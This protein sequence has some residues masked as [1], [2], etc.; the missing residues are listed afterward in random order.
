MSLKIKIKKHNNIPVV[1]IIGEAVGQDVVKISKKLEPYLTTSDP[2]IAIDL[3]GTTVV[4]SYGLGVFIFSWKQFTGQNRQLI[5]VNPQGFV[6]DLFEGTNL[7]KVLK[8]SE[9]MDTL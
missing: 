8:I 7:D 1:Q 5:F 6:R 9:S 4:D 3:G 2:T